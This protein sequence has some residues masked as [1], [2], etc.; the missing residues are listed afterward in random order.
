MTIVG[1]PVGFGTMVPVPGRDN[2]DQPLDRLKSFHEWLAETVASHPGALRAYAYTNPFGG[3]EL[4]AQTAETVRDG[5]FVGLMVNTSVRGEYL[6]SDGATP[7][8]EMASDLSVPVFVHPPAEPVGTSSMGDFRLVTHLARFND[9]T[10]CLAKLAFSG[11][12]DRH[13]DV[14]VIAP[15]AGGSIALLP[16]RLDLARSERAPGPPGPPEPPHEPP[17]SALGR[18]YLDTSTSSAA[19]LRADLELVGAERLLFGTDSPPTT[20]PVERG[21]AMVDALPLS[22][23]DKRDVLGGNAERLFGLDDGA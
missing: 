1:S 14:D 19:A 6:D 15:M 13:P 20:V 9:V 17:S 7:F 22:D 10:A 8:F 3:D 2:Y 12:L 16:E 18:V 5:G 21:L 23:G 4:L 11:V